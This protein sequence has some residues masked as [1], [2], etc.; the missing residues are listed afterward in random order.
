MACHYKGLQK[1]GDKCLNTR[2]KCLSEIEGLTNDA[3]REKLKQDNNQSSDS[4][5]LVETF[6]ERVENGWYEKTLTAYQQDLEI[7]K[8]LTAN[9]P[10]EL[11]HGDMHFGNQFEKQGGIFDLD[12]MGVGHAFM[13]FCQ[14]LVLNAR[15]IE[16]KEV[17]FSP[18]YAADYLRG[19]EQH[20]PLTEF[21]SKNL[22]K[23][24]ELTHWR[25]TATRLQSV[26]NSVQISDITKSPVELT[27]LREKFVNEHSQTKILASEPEKPKFLQN[28]LAGSNIPRY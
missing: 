5:K 24:I 22:N 2:Q 25:S 21:E 10:K 1:P 13:D 6:I 3:I 28:A 14:P 26:I 11:L 27:D 23:L 9:M 8:R 7:Y 20:R 19:L 4:A 12:W 18:K 17:H 15:D 16:N